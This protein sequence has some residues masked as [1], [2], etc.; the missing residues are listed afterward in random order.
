PRAAVRPFVGWADQRITLFDDRLV[1]G[2]RYWV[3]FESA[4]D[5]SRDWSRGTATLRRDLADGQLRPHVRVAV[6]SV[7][8]GPCRIGLWTQAGDPLLALDDSEFTVTAAPIAL[9]DFSETVTRNRYQAGV[10]ADGTVYIPVDVS[11][12]TD[13]TTFTGQAIG[14]PMRFGSDNVA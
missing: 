9:H 5:G 14:F 12:V 3:G 2:Q 4:A 11:Q 10:G 6:G 1:P 13:A 7:S 8:F